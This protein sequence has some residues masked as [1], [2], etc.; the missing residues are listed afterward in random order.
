MI[1]VIVDYVITVTRHNESAKNPF[2]QQPIEI[3]GY[4]FTQYKSK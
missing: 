2:R 3:C 1:S 4:V